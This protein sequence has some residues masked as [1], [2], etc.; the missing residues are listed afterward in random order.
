MVGLALPSPTLS[1]AGST[2][3]VGTVG[4]A[5][6]VPQLSVA[7]A[8]PFTGNVGLSLLPQLAVVGTTG[9]AGAVALGLKAL[10]L[11]VS[12]YTGAVGSASLTLPVLQLGVGGSENIVGSVTLQIPL[13]VLQAT[14]NLPAGANSTTVVM[15]TES[16][17]LT[18][19]SNYAFNSF[20][21]FGGVYLGANA[22]GIFALTG[23]TDNGAII[24]AAATLGITDF[25]SSHQKRVDRCYVGYRTTGD[26]VLRVTNDESTVRDYALRAT[27]NAGLHGNHVRIGKGVAARYW[28][29]EILNTNGADFE[30][31]IM[32]LKPTML[33]RRIGGSDG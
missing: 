28:Q 15:H 21:Q 25:G 11:A 33:K 23:A 27:G 26:L 1:V 5:L 20:A 31:D 3:V 32:E 16:M 6:P 10:A 2:G 13:L 7:G 29:F 12:G 19:Y 14:G 9:A 8:V 4:L 17:A 22:N 18:T 24:A 30:L